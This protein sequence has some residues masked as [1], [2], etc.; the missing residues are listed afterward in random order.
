MAS[1]GVRGFGARISFG[2]SRELWLIEAGVFLN[3]LG[4]GGVLP[5]EII[6]PSRTRPPRRSRRRPARGRATGC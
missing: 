1:L 4:Y 2:L 5:F 3:M 6:W